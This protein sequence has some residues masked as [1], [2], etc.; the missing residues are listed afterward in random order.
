MHDYN[1]RCL[2]CFAIMV[3]LT[4]KH[5]ASLTYTGLPIIQPESQGSAYNSS[6][7]ILEKCE[8]D[9]L[10]AESEHCLRKNY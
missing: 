10:I 8:T 4:S 5:K 6:E 9:N 3:S 7:V 1:L 2:F